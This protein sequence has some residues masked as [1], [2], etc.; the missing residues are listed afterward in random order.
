MKEHKNAGFTLVEV[1]VVI[2]ILAVVIGIGFGGMSI[3]KN[4]DVSKASSQV[5]SYY[6]ELKSTTMSKVGEWRLEI[7]RDDNDMYHAAIYNGTDRVGDMEEL[8][9]YIDIYFKDELEG[10]NNKITK[11]S[12][13][14]IKIKAST[15][16][17]SEISYGGAVK[18]SS[19]SGSA[20][21]Y[22]TVEIHL[23]GQKR[24][25]FKI[26]YITGKLVK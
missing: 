25:E 15:G 26:Y 22:G 5:S 19:S 14:I 17:V 13:L 8:G 7:T 16:G 1:I 24:E 21:T 4:A 20:S 23:S 18:F 6:E 12:P 9:K 10:S 11:S 2:A 3:L